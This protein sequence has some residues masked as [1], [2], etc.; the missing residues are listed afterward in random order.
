MPTASITHNVK[1]P[2]A[3]TGEAFGFVSQTTRTHSGK[4]IRNVSIYPHTPQ[5]KPR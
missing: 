2:P 3:T 1:T 5:F 4:D